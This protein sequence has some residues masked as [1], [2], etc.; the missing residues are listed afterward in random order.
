MILLHRLTPFAITLT[1]VAGYILLIFYPSHLFVGLFMLLVA[2]PLLFARL[3]LWEIKRGSFWV[4][5]GVPLFFILSS[6]FYFL[7]LE[8]VNAELFLMFVVATGLW[9]YAENLFTFYHLPAMYQA[10]AL[11]Y[12]TLVIVIISGFLFSAASYASTLFLQLPIWLPAIIMFLIAFLLTTSVYWVSKITLSAGWKFAT[13]GA[14]VI[15]QIYIALAML[16]VSFMANAAV[17]SILLYMF[18]GLS[19]ARIL[20]KLTKVVLK[21]YL[22]I[23][24]I[25]LIIIFSTARWV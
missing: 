25:L 16:P 9:F 7:F 4:F 14:L 8:S 15:T 11:E 6:V 1:A 21:R 18:L 23:G 19:R 2:I 5:F 17:I 22:V 20:R 12:L 24:S 3:L 13:I 10:Y